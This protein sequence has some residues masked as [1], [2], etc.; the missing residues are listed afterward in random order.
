M[1]TCDR[2]FIRCTYQ[3]VA[4]CY[5]GDGYCRDSNG[6]CIPYPWW[7]LQLFYE[8]INIFEHFKIFT[9]FDLHTEGSQL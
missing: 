7:G 9:G 2:I 3:C 6:E 1:D 5:C 8:Q 4:G